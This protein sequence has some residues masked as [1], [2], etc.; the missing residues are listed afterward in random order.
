MQCVT[1]GAAR[2][3]PTCLVSQCWWPTHPQ[4][5]PLVCPHPHTHIITHSISTYTTVT[6]W[7]RLLGSCVNITILAPQKYISED[8]FKCCVMVTVNCVIVNKFTMSYL[9]EK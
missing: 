3:R 6:T 2:G 5:P 4:L 7:K 9:Q 8:L 1:P